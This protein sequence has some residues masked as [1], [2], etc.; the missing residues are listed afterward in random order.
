VERKGKIEEK[1]LFSIYGDDKPRTSKLPCC[2]C[3]PWQWNKL[4]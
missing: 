4:L 3:V 2:A 1:G